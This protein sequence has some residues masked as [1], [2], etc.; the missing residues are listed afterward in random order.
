M[1]GGA[2]I[3][4]IGEDGIGIKAGIGDLPQ[5]AVTAH[6]LQVLANFEMRETCHLAKLRPKDPG[7]DH[8][9]VTVSS[10]LQSQTPLTL[11]APSVAEVTSDVAGL[12]GNM[13]EEVVAV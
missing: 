4:A 3:S 2:E 12:T 8:G 9:K 13:I 6:D 1:L 10:H 5:Q 7:E 11:L